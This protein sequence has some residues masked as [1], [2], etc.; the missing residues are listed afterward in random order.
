MKNKEAWLWGGC[1]DNVKFGLKFSRRFLKAGKRR[2]KD[3]RAKLDQHNIRLGRKVVKSKV[4][5]TC[6]CHGIS[7]SCTTRTC[8]RE[9]SPFHL[10]GRTLKQKYENSFKV[11]TYANQAT[12]QSQLVEGLLTAA[13]ENSDSL[14]PK[15]NVMVH[16]EDSPN[17]CGPS[18]YSPGTSGRACAQ[19]NCDVMCCGRGYNVK[20]TLVKRTCQCQVIWCCYVKCKQCISEEEIY[21]CK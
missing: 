21:L 4:R 8:W 19:D 12:G 20:T 18:L 9:L 3:I 6:K 14:P 15:R 1:G 2:G 7:G 11:V 17:F 10:I 16:L 5:T 13:G